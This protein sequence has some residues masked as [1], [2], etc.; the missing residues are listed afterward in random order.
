MRISD[1]SSDVCSSD[2]N[3]LAHLRAR[4][5]DRLNVVAV[6]VPRFDNERDA[7]R[8]AKRLSRQKL[9]FPIAH[10]PDWT[11]WQHY[12]IEAWPTVVLIDGAGNIRE[13]WA[14]DGQGREPPPPVP[15]RNPPHQPHPP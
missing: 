10:A 6:H 1:W 15:S 5:G 4:H 12:G 13:R 9:E 7:R 14:G 3:D 2:L 8:V 11:L